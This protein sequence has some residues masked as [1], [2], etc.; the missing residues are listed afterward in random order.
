MA[1]KLDITQV[2]GKLNA[3]EDKFGA[4]MYLFATSGA[5]KMEGWAKENRPWTDRTGAA[6][7]R[8]KGSAYQIDK[9]YRL[10]I[11]HGVNYGIFLELAHERRFAILE[12]TI[13]T[14]GKGQIMPAFERFIE[15]TCNV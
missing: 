2:M 12:P 11:A 14:V 10:E 1:F 3:F 8:L 13:Q 4:A 7:Q 9:G 15:R 6:R 5:Q